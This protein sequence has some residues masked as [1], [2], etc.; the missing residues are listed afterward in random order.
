[1][2]HAPG[3]APAVSPY[4]A[5]LADLA[6]TAL[7][8]LGIEAPQAAHDLQGSGLPGGRDLL[9]ELADGP[10]GRRTRLADFLLYGPPRWSV[11]RGPWKLVL[12][13]EPAPA[14]TAADEAA[15]PAT[16]LFDLDADPG[17]R[18]DVAALHPDVAADLQALGE[19]ELERRA[20]LRRRLL[21][22][23]DDVLN[24]AYLE[25]VHI[26]KL[27]ALGYLK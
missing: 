26:T 10:P 17:E 13:S 9:A 21:S 27:R 4:P 7:G 25:W 3:L 6:P 24:A 22:G 23:E 8:L 5:E 20:E 14:G 11:R 16:Q 12:A 2:I 15:A 18:R 1:V 19:A